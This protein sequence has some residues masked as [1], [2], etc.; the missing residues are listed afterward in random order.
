MHVLKAKRTQISFNGVI[1]SHKFEDKKKPSL[2]YR[3]LRGKHFRLL[4]CVLVF[5]KGRHGT[6]NTKVGPTFVQPK[7]GNGL[8]TYRKPFA[9]TLW[10][11]LLRRLVLL[12]RSLVVV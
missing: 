6:F 2:F 10:I 4:L 9:R 7:S 3:S 5:V 11:R 8:R 12:L 1:L